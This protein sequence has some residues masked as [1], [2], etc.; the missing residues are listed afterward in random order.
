ML[1]E[2]AFDFNIYFYVERVYNM[3]NGNP[4]YFGPQDFALIIVRTIV[5]EKETETTS[6]LQSIAE[7][8]AVPKSEL[9]KVVDEYYR[10]RRDHCESIDI[11]ILEPSLSDLKVL[12]LNGK[13]EVEQANFFDMYMDTDSTE[14][15]Y[16]IPKEAKITYKYDTKHDIMHFYVSGSE[17]YIYDD[18]ISSDG[19][20]IAADETTGAIEKILVFD[21][22]TN[23]TIFKRFPELKDAM[24][25][26]VVC[27]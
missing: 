9:Q 19:V 18:D 23:T 26:K 7:A 14:S 13:K 16:Y 5:K 24:Q 10:I 20:M 3:S 27:D 4:N 6:R 12:S 8:F 22:N 11:S 25:C 21:F 17:P 1:T 2:R 15:K